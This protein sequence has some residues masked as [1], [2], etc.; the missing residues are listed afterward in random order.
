[1]LLSYFSVLIIGV[2]A[3]FRNWSWLSAACRWICVLLLVATIAESIAIYFSITIKNSLFVF[4]FYNPVEIFMISMYFNESIPIFKKKNAGL[5]IGA[6]SAA[7]DICNTV[8]LQPLSVTNSNALHFASFA[9][10]AM[11]V[12]AFYRM[13]KNE[14]ELIRNPHF[15]ITSILMFYWSVTFLYWGMESFFTTVLRAYNDAFFVVF[16]IA[17]IL[18]YGGIALIFI[19][20]PK[21]VPSK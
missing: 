12:F 7:V 17:N 11:S 14:D 15:W 10:I 20:Y 16:G 4:H 2:L 18:C 13:Y 3:G 21:I 8:F 19:L 9:V 6:F 5:W 1:M